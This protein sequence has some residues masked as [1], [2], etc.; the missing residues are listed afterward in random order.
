MAIEEEFDIELSNEVVST[1]LTVRHLRDAVATELA[2]LHRP[3]E[4]PDA[5]FE[6]LRDMIAKQAGIQPDRVVLDAEIVR[7]LRI[8]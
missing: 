3:V 5:L 8:D 7:D 6:K 4:N 1:I 2:R